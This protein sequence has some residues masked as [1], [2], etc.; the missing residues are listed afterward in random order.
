MWHLI[1]LPLCVFSIFSSISPSIWYIFGPFYVEPAPGRR[2][3]WSLA[4]PA[5][6]RRACWSSERTNRGS[7]PRSWVPH[8][9]NLSTPQAHTH[10]LYARGWQAHSALADD[11]LGQ[12]LTATRA[13]LGGEAAACTQ[14]GAQLWAQ[15]QWLELQDDTGGPEL[16]PPLPPPS[17]ARLLAWW[18]WA[19]G[20]ACRWRARSGTRHT[21]ARPSFKAAQPGPSEG[22]AVR[23]VYT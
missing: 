19:R 22:Q 11:M 5:P 18:W 1:S 12:S 7:L 13:M 3:H 20:C 14:G 17:N 21:P 23:H 8:A 9:F 15:G 2:R 16:L 10:S 4:E 6:G